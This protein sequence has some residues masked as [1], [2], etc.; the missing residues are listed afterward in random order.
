M[1][2]EAEAVAVAV[3][4]VAVVFVVVAE[5]GHSQFLEDFKPQPQHFASECIKKRHLQQKAKG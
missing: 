1:E 4:V 5:V 3:G 2:A